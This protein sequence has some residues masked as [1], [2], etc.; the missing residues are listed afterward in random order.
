MILHSIKTRNF[1]SLQDCTIDQFD[2][3][4]NFLVGP[5]GCGKTT[6]FRALKAI[7]N[8]FN[9][10][11][12]IPVPFN[13]L[14]TRGISP[15]EI[16]LT[17]DVEFN[18][19]W[20]QELITTFLC[21]SLSRP[22][23][24]PNVL[25]PKLPQPIAQVSAEGFASFSDWLLRVF[26]PETLPFLFRGKLHLSYRSQS[27]DSLRLNYTFAHECIPITIIIR[28]FDGIMV[29]GNVP[30][31]IPGGYLPI[32][33][34]VDYF[35]GTNSLLDVVNLLTNQGFPAANSF[36]PIACLL[37][38]SEKRVTLG[39]DSINSQQAFLPAQRRFSELSGNLDLAN[40]SS[41]SFSFGYVIQ[42]LLQ[43][44]FVFTNNLRV[45][46]PDIATFSRK[47]S[48]QPIID[49]DDERQIPLLLY[50]LKNGESPERA[51]FQ[52]IQESFGKLTG[53]NLT[54]D[55][56][57]KL[58]DNEQ[59]ALSI[60]IRIIDS[61]S[62][63]SLAYHGA[64]I[65]EA[66]IL[67]TILDESDGRV[68]LLDEPA[69]NLHP[70][71]QR[72]LIE[73]LHNVP[74]QV[75]VVTH[76]AHILPTTAE[77]FRK[78]WRL[79]KDGGKTLV[80]SIRN[81]DWLKANKL[82]KELNRSSD[83][84]GLVFVDGVILVEGETETGALDK[85]FLSSAVGKGKTFSDLNLSVYWVEGKPNFPFYMHFLQALG[86]PWVI[87]CDGDAIPPNTNKHIW[88]TLKSLKRIGEADEVFNTTASF[89]ELKTL[90]ER[91]GVYTANAS[92]TESFEDIPEVKN[93]ACNNAVFGRGKVLPGRYIAAQIPCPKAVE[94]VLELAIRRLGK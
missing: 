70:G 58:E 19:S 6:V 40:Q 13:Q 77:D 24:L 26:R 34:L 71:L 59:T 74:G 65:W 33:V 5:N 60:D 72:R 49:F 75:I 18:T 90:A 43:H 22:Y 23:D 88:N 56:Y 87:I 41:R 15:Q 29:R 61:G 47:E 50:R 45:P 8:T 51:R 89:Q 85:W 36:D 27:Y 62:E 81:S 73:I 39:I 68:V 10:E 17:L 37:Y 80:Y 9:F 48:V 30:D 86:I 1:M 91:A 28:P 12:R 63:I 64:G 46:I 32:N 2:S 25:S 16:D 66:L 20:E 14:C 83:L 35:E 11:K 84:A 92:P 7:Y 31:N 53:T 69:S 54:F 3:H 4:L 76:S 57:A 21:A 44:A 79:Q 42:I 93:Y 94:E 52:R 82:E 55:I 67:S 38:L 78:V